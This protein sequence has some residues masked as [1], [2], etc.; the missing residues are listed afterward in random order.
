MK[1]KKTGKGLQGIGNHGKYRENT[2]MRARSL[3]ALMCCAILTAGCLA[4]CGGVPEP[5]SASSESPAGSDTSDNAVN[6]AE[7]SAYADS[8]ETTDSADSAD[9][10]ETADS[11]ETTDS[12]DSAD[13]AETAAAADT[14]AAAAGTDKEAAGGRLLKYIDAWDEWHTMTVD[15][16]VAET[17]YDAAQF[18]SS[19]ENPQWVIYTGKDAEDYDCLQG[20]DV[21]EHQGIIDWQ[22]VA[23]AGYQFA[24]I[25]V[26]YRGYGEAGKLFEDYMAVENLQQAKAAGLHVGTYLF[27]QALN[28]EEAVEEASL[29]VSVI[30]KSGVE[31]DLP[32]MYDPE[33]IKDDQGRANDI[34]REQVALNTAAFRKTVENLSSCSVDIY[35]NLPWEHHYFDTDTMNQYDI[36]YADYEPLP[37]TPYHFT[38]WQYTN[39]G[40][41]PGIGGVVDLDLWLRKK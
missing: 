34:T 37:Q 18:A 16:A 6:T 13:S 20:I 25:R 26:G 15:P 17:I 11:A 12:A 40:T 14:S 22:A 21:S 31:T 8:A 19:E 1:R 3:A 7:S 23:D 35:S 32:L 38:W 28:E 9:F 4:G 27:S 29:A 24:F 10:A 41:V 2:L 5:S 30:E 36:W 39:E 33:I